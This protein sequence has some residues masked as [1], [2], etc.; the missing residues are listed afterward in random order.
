MKYTAK[1][2]SPQERIILGSIPEPM[3]GCWIWL[4]GTNAKG[5]A[6]LRYNTK[7]MRG[8]R[9]AWEAFKGL[10]PDSLLVLHRC[11]NRLCVN[12]EHLFLGTDLENAKDRDAK[13]RHITQTPRGSRHGRSKFRPSDIITIRHSSETCTAL[14]QKYGVTPAAIRF[15]KRRINWKHIQEG[16]EL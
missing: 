7:M 2:F 6:H 3:S 13:G 4:G 1:N 14:A 12:P 9:F 5:Y 16:N 10:I 15:I 11:D 8:N